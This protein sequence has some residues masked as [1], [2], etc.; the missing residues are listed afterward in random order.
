MQHFKIL[1]LII[2]FFQFTFSNTRSLR[3]LSVLNDTQV[4]VSGS[5]GYIGRLNA[6]TLEACNVPDEYRNNY[7]RD[8]HAFSQDHAI[9]ISVSDSGVLLK[10]RDFGQTWL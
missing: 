8:I 7:F 2:V 4:W 5:N 10:T 3:G 1:S 6:D 9:A